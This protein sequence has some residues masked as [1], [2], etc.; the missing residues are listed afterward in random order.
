MRRA[1][2]A[3]LSRDPHGAGEMDPGS[4]AHHFALRSIRG[5]QTRGPGV[6]PAFFH[7]TSVIVREGGRSSIPRLLDLS[8]AAAITGCPRS[9]A[10]RLKEALH[11]HDFS[12]RSGIDRLSA[13]ADPGAQHASGLASRDAGESAFG[14]SRTRHS[15]REAMPAL[16]RRDGLWR[17]DPAAVRHYGGSR[18]VLVAMEHSRAADTGTSTGATELSCRGA[19]RS[20]AV[21]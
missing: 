13:A 8:V 18:F 4:A 6:I 9:R 14:D 21:C 5:T 15:H 7:G 10:G 3:S 1:C 17:C 19:I 12:L 2:A 16:F 20:C 11:A